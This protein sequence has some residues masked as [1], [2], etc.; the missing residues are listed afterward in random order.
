[1]LELSL[2][3]IQKRFLFFFIISTMMYVIITEYLTSSYSIEKFKES[4]HKSGQTYLDTILDLQKQSVE[5]LAI[6]L[7]DDEI[8]KRGYLEND[9]ELIKQHLHSFWQ[10]VKSKELIYEIHFFK[11]PAISFVNFS[12]FGSIGRD[13]SKVRSDIVWVTSS[14]NSSNHIMMCKTYA[15]IRATYPI[16]ADDGTILG[17]VSLGK[18]VDWIPSVMK[19][20]SG[21]D[22]FLLYTVASTSSLAPK[23]LDNFM[24][25]KKHIGDYILAES[26]LPISADVIAGLDMDKPMQSM[27]IDDKQYLLSLYPIYDFSGGLMAYTGVLHSYDAIY[28]RLWDRIKYDLLFI[29]LLMIALF[30]IVNRYLSKVV[31]NIRSIYLLTEQY[32]QRRFDKIELTDRE[33]HSQDEISLLKRNVIAMGEIIHEDY[34]DLEDE[35][36]EKTH[37]IQEAYDRLQ[38]THYRDSLTKLPNRFALTRDL[39][40]AQGFLLIADIN[41]FKVVNDTYGIETGNQLL[42][43]VAHYL[44]KHCS[45]QGYQVYRIASDE[46]AIVTTDPVVEFSAWIV[47]L[48]KRLEH[49]LFK[50]DHDEIEITVEMNGGVGKIGENTLE[51]ADLALQYA[52]KHHIGYFVYDGTQPMTPH[53]DHLQ[54]I[55][56]IKQAIS[57]DHIIPYY[58][59]IVDGEGKV[60]KYEA[61]MRMYDGEKILTPYHFLENAKRSKYYH[62]M[63]RIMIE[64][65]FKEFAATDLGVNI[66]L[67]VSDITNTKTVGLLL[68]RLH[69]FPNPTRVTFELV[70]SESIENV[71]EVLEFVTAVKAYGAKV[72]ID[73]FG[74]GYSNFSYLMKISPDLVKIDGSLI[75][76]IDHDQNSYEVVKGIVEFTYTLKME[77]VGEFVHSKAVYEKAKAIGID[78]FQGYYFHEPEADIFKG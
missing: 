11:P 31:S 2:M 30:V 77:C 16:I 4:R 34:E 35:V 5:V 53:H 8:I 52:K 50:F 78:T 61:L 62:A 20:V 12:D 29:I 57:D 26:T 27:T 49:E 18:K 10:N 60:L 58:Q 33:R 75:R 43:Q 9:P 25:G 42:V 68:T 13:L 76:N 45:E 63:S 21:D 44:Q 65:A 47:D 1:M 59:A 39:S 23:Y 7:S 6:S 73:D 19:R 24:K 3:S 40:K 17:G 38:K 48:F 51:Q 67:T 70:E 46:F 55:K 28:E 56:K 22:S 66:N 71:S 64:K 54:M 72:A 14:F 41:S 37:Q 74:S 32:K 15:G 36:A 69:D